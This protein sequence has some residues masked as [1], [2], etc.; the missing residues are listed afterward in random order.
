M[1]LNHSEN[2]ALLQRQPSTT[3]YSFPPCAAYNNQTVNYNQDYG[4]YCQMP[5]AATNYHPPTQWNHHYSGFQDWGSCY[6][7]PSPAYPS[8]YPGTSINANAH[9]HG[10]GH[11]NGHAVIDYNIPENSHPSLTVLGTP[12]PQP[13]VSPAVSS[14][15]SSSDALSPGSKQRQPYDWMKR[16]T[17]QCMPTA[18]ELLDNTQHRLVHLAFP[19]FRFHQC[20]T[21]KRSQMGGIRKYATMN[22]VISISANYKFYS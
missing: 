13:S 12:Q 9:G 5:D 20:S 15:G 11:G 17:Y 21:L 10:H 1:V 2:M 22:Y 18:G 16:T 4:Q 8:S 7:T 6:N 14:G 19:G 3:N